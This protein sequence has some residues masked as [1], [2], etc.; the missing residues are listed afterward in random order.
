[1]ANS[2]NNSGKT[3]KR[4]L[5]IS[6]H[7][8][9]SLEVGGFRAAMF[10]K[11]LPR[12]DW[13]CSVLTIDDT[14]LGQ[15]DLK[16]LQEL[17][18]VNI[19]RAPQLPT[20][21]GLYAA[22]KKNCR[23]S[24]QTSSEPVSGPGRQSGTEQIA[25]QAQESLRQKIRRYLL[26]F[27][28][29][30][31]VHRAWVVPAFF[32]ALRRIRHENIECILTTSPPHSVHLIGLLLKIF[33]G[34]Q[35]IADFRD[36]WMTGGYKRLF[37]TC[38]ASMRIERWM[39]RLIIQKADLV[40]TNTDA[41][42]STFTTAYRDQP[43]GKFLCITN[44]I[45]AELY[46]RYTHMKKYDT[47]TITHAGSLYFGRSPEPVFTALRELA[48]EG[49]LDLKRVNV[50]LLGDCYF[51]GDLPTVELIKREA[52][53]SVV[54]LIGPVSYSEALE[55]IKRSH[56]AL[57]LAPDQP[58]QIPAKV[59][60]YMGLGTTILALAGAGVTTDLI[61]A[62]GAGVAV[63]P[64]DVQGIKSVICQ[65]YGQREQLQSGGQ[66]PSLQRFDTQ[67]LTG[68]LAEQLDGLCSVS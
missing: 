67:L 23:K 4:V 43:Q 27:L 24:Q 35:W 44:G 56:I 55:T 31:D 39:E 26:A 48:Q 22:V 36:P 7:F 65:L 17:Q 49:H 32:T 15:R 38:D 20:M 25:Q 30:P 10:A 63:D 8:P 53:D 18:A 19:L 61:R 41:L 51:T 46:A 11:H 45:D 14:N 52:L 5:I 37:I 42:C 59:Y 29:M 47:F 16:R 57:L 12:F 58:R 60:D 9:P 1:M 21:L 66:T 68:H 6:Y 13:Q 62:T 34:V 54:E 33:S 3:G 28:T 2:T 64:T 40:L 50:K